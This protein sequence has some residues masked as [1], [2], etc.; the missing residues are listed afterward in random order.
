MQ[1]CLEPVKDTG[2]APVKSIPQE[3]PAPDPTVDNS[4]NDV[5][6]PP[7][8]RPVTTDGVPPAPVEA[9]RLPAG[10]V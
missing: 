8:S 7:T 1:L 6:P 5:K 2:I 3:F 10:K 4:Q 9:S